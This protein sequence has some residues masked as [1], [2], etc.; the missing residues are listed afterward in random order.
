[1]YV[2]YNEVEQEMMYVGW[3]DHDNEVDEAKEDLFQNICFRQD[4]W[5]MLMASHL[6][7]QPNHWLQWETK[8]HTGLYPNMNWK[9]WEVMPQQEFQLMHGPLRDNE[10]TGAFSNCRPFTDQ[11]YG[12]VWMITT[13]IKI[14][15]R[16]S[17]D[18]EDMLTRH[19]V[20]CA[21][22][23]PR[24][25]DTAFSKVEIKTDPTKVLKWNFPSLKD[26]KINTARDEEQVRDRFIEE[27]ISI[28]D[29][30]SGP[31]GAFN[32]V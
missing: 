4:K 21:H 32:C 20:V 24:F 30:I 16:R 18:T 19:L 28:D 8:K 9:E 27:G 5:K 23:D 17:A 14:R 11:S 25:R 7:L 10:C 15:E 31:N 26:E 12:D 1:M 22:E 13:S 3:N 2:C 29:L 6:Q